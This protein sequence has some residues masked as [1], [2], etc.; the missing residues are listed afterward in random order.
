M[1][2]LKSTLALSLLAVF[3]VACGSKSN[4]VETS[5]AKEVASADDA[6]AITVNTQNSMVTWIGSK[7]TGKHNGSISIADGEIMV[8]NSEIVGGNFTIDIT[9]LKALDMEE[10]TDGYNNLVGHLMSPDFFDAENH[11]TATFE[12]TEVKPFSAANLSADKDE[13]DSENKPAALSEV[14]VENPTHFISGNLTMRGT[15]KNITFPAHVEMNNGVIKAKANFNIDRT[16]WG[17]S[18]NT[19][20]NFVDQAKD[21]MIYDTVNVGFELEAGNTSASE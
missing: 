1:K 8:N 13:Y 4:T 17:L 7:P 14:M 12:V 9:S 6:T 10:G 2:F 5:E 21:K 19:E 3:A 11:P 20:A 15:T 16:A 18:Y